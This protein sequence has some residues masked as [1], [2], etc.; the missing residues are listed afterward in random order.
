[1]ER[2][3]GREGEFEMFPISLVEWR[4]W[5]VPEQNP[6]RDKVSEKGETNAEDESN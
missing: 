5:P 1:M 6:S 3:R 2:V 4:C